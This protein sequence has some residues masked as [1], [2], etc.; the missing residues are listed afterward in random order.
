[1]LIIALFIIVINEKQPKYPPAKKKHK[2]QLKK[3]VV[4]P[5]SG[6]IATKSNKVLKFKT[7][8]MDHKGSIQSQKSQ[9]QKI[10]CC[11][12]PFTQHS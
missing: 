8:W 3:T 5:Y 7:T 12:I 2:K 10:A 9:S 11:M 1:M 6:I 4:F